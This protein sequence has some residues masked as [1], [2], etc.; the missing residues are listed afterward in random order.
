M[1]DIVD[2]FALTLCYQDVERSRIYRSTNE[3]IK[4]I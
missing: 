3:Y 2:E 1:S 4:A